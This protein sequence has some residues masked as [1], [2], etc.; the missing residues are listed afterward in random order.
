M[1]NNNMNDFKRT[2]GEFKANIVKEIEYIR[3]VPNKNK[4]FKE[5]MWRDELRKESNKNLEVDDWSMYDDQYPRIGPIILANIE[6]NN[7]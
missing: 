4:E 2:T 3:H 1:E 6:D 7:M 5:M